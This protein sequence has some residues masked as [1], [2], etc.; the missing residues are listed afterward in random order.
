[1]LPGFPLDGAEDCGAPDTHFARQVSEALA[2][3]Y[4]TAKINHRGVGKLR[5]A[6]GFAVLLRAV[7][8]LVGVV[9]FGRDIREV[10]G[11][12]VVHSP[13]E[14]AAMQPLWALAVEC[15]GDKDMNG[16]RLERAVLEQGDQPVTFPSPCV[17]ANDAAFYCANAPEVGHIIKALIALDRQPR[18]SVSHGPRLAR[19]KA[20]CK[21]L[22]HQ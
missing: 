8:E 18:F 4:S 13:I 15:V 20:L 17:A 11:A 21:R 16:K 7:K 9:F 1:M 3:P 10:G 14:M 19:I 22:A 5:A 12:V 2:I 6:V